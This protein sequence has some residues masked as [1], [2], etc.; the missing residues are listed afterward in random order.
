[1]RILKRKPLWIR[2]LSADDAERWKAV[3]E[4]FALAVR[5]DPNPTPAELEA[6]GHHIIAG[7]DWSPLPVKS[8]APTVPPV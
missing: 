2:C 8:E 5:N 3:A 4:A 1:L 6:L 7:G